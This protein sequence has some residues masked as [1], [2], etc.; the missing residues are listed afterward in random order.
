MITHSL[1]DGEDTY[2][3][4]TPLP[5]D[6][7]GEGGSW[8]PPSLVDKALDWLKEKTEP[9]TSDIEKRAAAAGAEG[10]KSAGVDVEAR[11]QSGLQPVQKAATTMTYVLVGAAAITA[12]AAG[13]MIYLSVKKGKRR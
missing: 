7:A 9:I 10:A 5:D 2:P 1:G 4:D 12:V 3:F 8:D 6:S 11:V 13:T